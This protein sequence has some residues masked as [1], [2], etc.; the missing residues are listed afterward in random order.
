MPLGPVMIDLVG[1]AI[2]DQEREWLANPLV[3]GV[4]LFTRNYESL[5][6]LEA[7]V[8]D[9]HASS[10]RMAPLLV[11]VDHEGGRVQRFR[12]GFTRLPA[13]AE[14]GA[15][16]RSDRKRGRRLAEQAGW[17]MASELRAVGVD[18]SFAPV[19]DIDYGVSSVIG[20]RAFYDSADGVADLATNFVAGMKQAGMSAVGKHFPGHGAVEVDSHLALPVDERPLVD[21][22]MADLIP[23]ERL[24]ANGLSGIMPAHILYS[25]IDRDLAGF[26]PFWL[27]HVLRGQMQ[28]QGVIFSDDLSMGGATGAGNITQRASKALEAGCDMVLVCNDPSSIA[29]LLDE[30]IYEQ[31]AVHNIRL[32]RLHGRHKITLNK[33]HADP[34]WTQS[35][36]ALSRIQDHASGSLDLDTL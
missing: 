36:H 10:K 20:D 18:F 34:H 24:I 8:A 30:L 21:I 17:V 9:I 19:L 7:L 14:I 28:F 2:S 5:E 23:F 13:A 26:S 4:I 22:T 6:Q 12:E 35:V 25:S 16:Y 27:Q 15:I 33:L 29:T 32:V 1:T 31:D 3:G 11:A